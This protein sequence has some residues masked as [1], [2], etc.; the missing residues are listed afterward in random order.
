MIRTFVL[1]VALVVAFGAFGYAQNMRRFDAVS[2]KNPRAAAG[3]VN[4]DG[5]IAQGNHFSVV[6]LETGEYELTFNERYFSNGCPILTIS[7]VSTANT[8][9]MYLR[10]CNVYDAYFFGPTGHLAD[11]EFNLI[12]VASE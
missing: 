9:R 10:R 3:Q 2:V 4:S 8:Y 7:G 12:A 1:G 5:S 11:T 6:H